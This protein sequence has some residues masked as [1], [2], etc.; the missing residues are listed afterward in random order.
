MGCALRLCPPTFVAVSTDVLSFFRRDQSA[1]CSFSLKPAKSSAIHSACAAAISAKAACPASVRRT[2]TARRS[3]SG[4][5]RSIRPDSASRSTSPVTLPFETIMRR[6][7]SP[8]SSPSSTRS[9]CA[10][11]SK[12][13]SVVPKRAR[14]RW[15]TSASIE[16]GGRQQP[17]PEPQLQPMI[18]RAV[19]D[20]RIPRRRDRGGKRCRNR[21]GRSCSPRVLSG[22]I[23]LSAKDC[24][25]SKQSPGSGQVFLPQRR[26]RES[27]S[28]Q[29]FS[30][31]RASPRPPPAAGSLPSARPCRGARRGEK[32][33][34]GPL[35][36]IS[37]PRMTITRSHSRRTT[38]RSWL[39]KA[40]VSQLVLSFSSS[41]RI[42]ALS[43][44]RGRRRSRRRA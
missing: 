31:T 24:F 41:D 23:A 8:S 13:G 12:R 16:A 34:R 20:L 27:T 38:E 35:S 18:H 22:W 36:R 1:S 37:P 2:R 15:R 19:G 4:T 40:S 21:M 33:G 39:M 3:S 28:S 44:R 42:C 32:L 9:S 29:R 5:L 43:T 7:S 25:M 11:R 6:D 14:S 30:P 26:G 17:Q 10:S